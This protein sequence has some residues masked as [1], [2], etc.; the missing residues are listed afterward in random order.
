MHYIITG[1]LRSFSG[2]IAETSDGISLLFENEKVHGITIYNENSFVIKL[3]CI[4][5]QFDHFLS[6]YGLNESL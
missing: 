2:K 1:K 6:I 5:L 3:L 4:Q